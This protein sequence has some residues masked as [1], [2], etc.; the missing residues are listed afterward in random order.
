MRRR[1]LSGLALGAALLPGCSTGAAPEPAGTLHV[2]AG[3]ELKDL[4]PILDQVRGATG[5]NLKLDYVGTLD[6]AEQI[7]SGDSHPLAWFSSNRY[8]TLLQGGKNRIVAQNQVMLSPVVMG[9]KHS[10]AVRL[11]WAGRTDLTWRDIAA[12]SKSGELRFAMTDPSASNS[13][14][15]ALVGVASAFSGSGS[16]IDAGHVDATAMKDFF[17]GQAATAGSSGFLAD[18]FVRSQNDLDGLINYESVLLSLNSGGKL[19]DQLDL[20]YPREGIVTADYPLMLLD[21]N[22]RAGYDKVVAYLRSTKVQQQI[23]SATGR[24]PAVP[25]ISLDQRFP[26]QV[27]VE[28]PFP[29]SLDAVNS[30]I[31]TYLD[32]IRP[33]STTTYVL[34]LS[35]SMQ[36]D[37]LNQL[38]RAL[39]NLTGLDSS[40]T[41]TFARFRRRERLTIITFSSTVQ[42]TKRFEINDV[43][44]QSQ[45]FIQLRAYI[46]SLQATGGTAIYEAMYHAYQLAGQD[47]ARDPGRFYSIVLL[48]D[49]ENNAGRDGAQFLKD[50]HALP[51]DTQKVKAFPILLGEANPDELK[52]LAEVSGGQDFDSRH[53]SLTQIF[54][55]VRGYG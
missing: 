3:S 28:L 14:F 34:D 26:S 1:W 6:G 19:R 27:L 31:T 36:G 49:G 13:G 42:D 9:I 21:R 16:A 32:Q 45:D 2:L 5:V 41:G 40:V 7:V 12:A 8:L 11:K 54:K 30:L 23:M 44:S 55:Q 18:A 39:T 52:T 50:F 43:S 33:P 53:A 46:N 38:K 22:Q 47:R 51:E 25:G 20:L 4:A 10:A 24:R 29:G 37:R 15:S 35:G 48:T 17:T